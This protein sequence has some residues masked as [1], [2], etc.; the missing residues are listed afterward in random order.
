MSFFSPSSSPF[1]LLPSVLAQQL[2][3]LL[4]RTFVSPR[5]FLSGSVI[6][7]SP[8]FFL[9]PRRCRAILSAHSAR[10]LP[11]CRISARRCIFS[12]GAVL[13]APLPLRWPLSLRPPPTPFADSLLAAVPSHAAHA[14]R[15]PLPLR[16][17]LSLPSPPSFRSSPTPPAGDGMWAG[18]HL[19]RSLFFPRAHDF[20]CGI[21]LVRSPQL[22]TSEVTYCRRRL[23][24]R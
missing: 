1:L 19:F 9:F 4:P 16:C 2:V 15:S 5:L 12:H 13:R 23:P 18:A 6:E 24:T 20:I 11:R 17:S 10:C 21:P 22:W 7:T 8:L 3:C 14:A